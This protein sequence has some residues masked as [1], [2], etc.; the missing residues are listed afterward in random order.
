MGSP[1]SPTRGTKKTLATEHLHAQ[2]W[3]L[4]RVFALP[5]YSKM[6]PAGLLHEAGD[7]S[8]TIMNPASDAIDVVDID[9]QG[10]TTWSNTGSGSLLLDHII[11]RDSRGEAGNMG[12][13]GVAKVECPGPSHGQACKAHMT[14]LARLN[15]A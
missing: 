2:Y 15:G 8:N 12:H 11:C 5:M 1:K 7:E 6:P 10:R 4:L 9:T 3:L 14:A 13:S